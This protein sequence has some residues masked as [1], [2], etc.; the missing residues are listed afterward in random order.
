M[1]PADPAVMDTVPGAA[2][3][4]RQGA[5]SSWNLHQ[6]ATSWGPAQMPATVEPLAPSLHGF[7]SGWENNWETSPHRQL[8]QVGRQR[9]RK[10]IKRSSPWCYWVETGWRGWG[11]ACCNQECFSEA[12]QATMEEKLPC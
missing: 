9:G 11:V 12:A 7:L 3:I 4:P 8:G 1:V 6:A 10:D 2:V 5:Q